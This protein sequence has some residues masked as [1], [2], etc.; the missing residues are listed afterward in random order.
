M[1]GAFLTTDRV[2]TVR[3]AR[4]ARSSCR[5][6]R[7]SPAPRSH[8][9][10]T[11]Q[12][13]HPCT[14]THPH[15]HT[16]LPQV[17][18]RLLP[19]D[20]RHSERGPRCALPARTPLPWPPPTPA[21]CFGRWGGGLAAWRPHRRSPPP[22]PTHTH[23]STHPTPACTG[24]GRNYAVNVPLRDG[25]TDE[26]YHEL[27]RPIM[28]RIMS[29]YQ[30]GAVVL[31]CGEGRRGDGRPA[32]RGRGTCVGPAPTHAHPPTL[33][34]TLTHPHSRSP[35]R[36]PPRLRLSGGRPAGRG[37]CTHSNASPTHTHTLPHPQTTQAPTLWRETAWAYSTSLPK[38]T[39]RV[40][41]TCAPTTCR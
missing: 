30:P 39:R 13:T 10:R 34:L 40:W 21:R 27:F 24:R 8:H 4:C 6:A 18:R 16:Q 15:A 14:H 9:A 23:T 19:G 33:T 41:S 11:P 36:K 2:M 12:F 29:Q 22:P 32:H 38:D 1:G 17:W 35:T 7:A 31:Q 5:S 20:G 25:V 3:C 28:Q 37:P 26:T